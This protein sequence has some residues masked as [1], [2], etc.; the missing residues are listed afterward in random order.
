LQF[1]G[2]NGQITWDD[3]VGL[4]HVVSREQV[5]DINTWVSEGPSRFFVDNIFAEI[6]H[7]KTAEPN[8]CLVIKQI[9]FLIGVFHKA[10]LNFRAAN[11]HL[12]ILSWLKLGN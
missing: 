6:L 1:E 8:V 12:A 3:V 5:K 7:I 9:T 4:A 2:I 11:Q 10:F